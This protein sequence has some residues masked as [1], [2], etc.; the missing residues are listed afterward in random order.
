MIKMRIVLIL[1]FVIMTHFSMEGQN[2]WQEII[3][4]STTL[5]EVQSKAEDF[6]QKRGTGKGSGFKQY[7]RWY[8]NM[9]YQVNAD[10]VLSNTSALRYKALQS[11]EK[12]FSPSNRSTNGDWTNLGP[13]DVFGGDVYSGPGLGRVNCMAFHPTDVNTFYAGTPAGGL[14]KTENNGTD[15]EPMTD[16]LPSIGI[17]E[18]IIH[19][20]NPLIMYILTGDGDSDDTPSIGV[21]KSTDGGESWE[22]TALTFLESEMKVGYRMVMNPNSS[23][24]ILVGLSN[25]GIIRTTNGFD[26]HT[27]VLTTVTVWDIE[28]APGNPNIV[29]A[30]T[31]NGIYRSEDAGQTWDGSGIIGLPSLSFPNERI[32]LAISPSSPSSV[33]V[34]FGEETSSGTFQG[35]YK[36]DDFGLEF[37]VQGNSPNILASNMDGSG[38]ANQAWYDLCILVHPENDATVFVGGVNMWKSNNSGSTWSRETWWTKNFEPID[39][40][41]HADWHNMYY[42]NGYLY[43]CNDGGIARS[44][45]EGNDWSDISQ[46]LCLMQFYKIDVIGNNYMGGS[47]DN[48]T[49]GGLY[50]S[51]TAQNILGGDGFGCAYHYGNTSI[52]YISNQGRIAR[53]Q[54]GSNIFIWEEAEAFWFTDI[55]MHKTNPGFIFI[56]KDNE[57]YRG[58]EN[59]IADYTWEDMG[60]DGYLPLYSYTAGQEIMGYT[61]NTEITNIMYLLG[62]NNVILKTTNLSSSAPSWTSIPDPTG[63]DA[64]LSHIAQDEDDQ[65]NVWLTCSGYIATDKVWYSDD[66][67]DSWDNITDNLPNIPVRCITHDSGTIYIGTAIGVYF[68]NESMSQ[69]A[70]FGNG[71][72]NV[73]VNDLKVYNGYLYAGTYGRG[74]WRSPIASPCPFSLTLTQANDPYLPGKEEI[75]VENNLSSSRIVEESLGKEVLYS[76]ENYLT[77]VPGFWAKSGSKLISKVG[78]C[79]Y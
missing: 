38:S 4:S 79:P 61:Q 70:Y 63:P 18:I 75:Y 33:Y 26:S 60:V 7:Q 74:L 23:N 14:W 42:H 25:G 46:N 20:T 58:S 47:Q 34:V 56:T 65:N 55:Q 24:D 22:E 72:P 13:F 44:A 51:T 30:A 59:T 36:S 50:N 49:N 69:W 62:T 16:G 12:I 67:G 43:S 8:Q 27:T 31:S 32:A 73:P 21:L 41:V 5:Q 17:S 19:P 76:T 71:L 29:Y 37:E 3:R 66:G 39:P 15:W 53:R 10:G 40:Y 9:Q 78:D 54:L 64:V 2:S 57:L 48:G 77:L 35:V 6:F 11:R 52:Q 45:D 28:Y 1:G 68:R